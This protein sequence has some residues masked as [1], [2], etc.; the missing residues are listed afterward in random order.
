VVALL[1][2]GIS[3]ILRG[4][5]TAALTLVGKVFTMETGAIMSMA[6]K[7]A[8]LTVTIVGETCTCNRRGVLG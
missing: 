5:A 4:I 2:Q 7:A 3:V 1:V 8:F 6:T